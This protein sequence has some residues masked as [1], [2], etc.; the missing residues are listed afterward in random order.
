MTN[1]TLTQE[2]LKSYL[3]YNEQTGEFTWIKNGKIA[4]TKDKNRGYITIQLNY[5]AYRAHRLAFLYMKG[6][7]PS[8]EIDH[9]DRNPSNNR[10]DNLHE[11]SHAD[12][13]LNKANSLNNKRSGFTYITGRASTNTWAVRLPKSYSEKGLSEYYVGAF[14]DLNSAIKALESVLIELKF[15]KGLIQF[16]KQ[17][18]TYKLTLNQR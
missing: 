5:K 7:L 9:K 15:E 16:Y 10:W 12:N 6:S 13:Q 18:E 3:K 1:N 4:G 8:L 11:V 2:I 17:L 14:K